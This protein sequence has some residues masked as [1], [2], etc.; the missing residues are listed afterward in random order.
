M[1]VANIEELG[2]DLDEGN[3]TRFF[4]SIYILI[5][6]FAFIVFLKE[7]SLDVFCRHT[8]L[9][10]GNNMTNG[11]IY[12]RM[13]SGFQHFK[14]TNFNSRTFHDVFNKSRINR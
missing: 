9:Q 12:W 5:L 14:N 3:K 8:S 11:Q 2:A 7:I 1:K 4:L 13:R 10:R 6:G